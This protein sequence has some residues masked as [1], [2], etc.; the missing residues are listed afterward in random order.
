MQ[1]VA[2]AGSSY[3][4]NWARRALAGDAPAG[5]GDPAYRTRVW[6]STSMLV[7]PIV[8]LLLALP[9]A[10]ASHVGGANRSAVAFAIVAGAVLLVADGL[11]SLMAMMGIVPI[12]T[13]VWT[14]PLLALA[15]ALARLLRAEV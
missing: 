14:V 12:L 9:M 7:L 8:M 10:A 11:M 1:V 2:A 6:R 15:L 4:A 5:L 13:G 3:S